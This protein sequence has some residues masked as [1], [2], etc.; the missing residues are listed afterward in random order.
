MSTLG[1]RIKR[2]PFLMN[3]YFIALVLPPHLNEKI[4][5]YKEWMRERFGTRVA[6]KSPAHITLVPPFWLEA[7]KEE[8]LIM[9]IKSVSR[10]ILSF[11]I[12]TLHFSAFV[13][14]TLFIAIAPNEELATLKKEADTYFR[15]KEGYKIKLDNRPFHPHITIAT[16]DLSKKAFHEAWP[17]FKETEFD[18]SWKS[19]GISLLR[20]NKKNWE[21]IYTSQFQ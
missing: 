14:R 12:R 15:E 13:P 18:A 17:H 6:L 4:Q 8:E 16:R 9:D 20:H 11:E 7:E 1:P 2:N 5:K 19:E 10:A 21:V 3:M